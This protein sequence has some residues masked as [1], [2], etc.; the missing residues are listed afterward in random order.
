MKSKKLI[1]VF[2]VLFVGFVGFVG[3]LQ[4]NN[5][6]VGDIDLQSLMHFNKVQAEDSCPGAT[7]GN[8]HW[9]CFFSWQDGYDCCGVSRNNVCDE[10]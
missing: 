6:T 8:K 9:G 2:L 4:T 1:S 10:C 3:S 7:G 5:S